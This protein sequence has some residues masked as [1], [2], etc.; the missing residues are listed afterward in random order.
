MAGNDGKRLIL[1]LRSCFHAKVHEFLD[2]A[3]QIDSQPQPIQVALGA[4]GKIAGPATVAIAGQA[5]LGYSDGIAE[6]KDTRTNQV[7]P[8]TVRPYHN[9]I[10]DAKTV[11]CGVSAM[12]PGKIDPPDTAA[13]LATGTNPAVM[14]FPDAATVQRSEVPGARMLGTYAGAGGLKIQFQATGAIIDCSQAHVASMYSVASTASGAAVV[15]KNGSSPIILALQPNGALAGAGTVKVDGRL[16]SGQ[17]S[18]GY[19]FTPISGSCAVGALA[20]AK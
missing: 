11:N 4:D 7:V 6:T 13:F 3:I 10:Y 20:L 8:G 18:S 15:L 2:A 9:P 1:S 17:N 14:L 19:V 5:I 12:S 16:V